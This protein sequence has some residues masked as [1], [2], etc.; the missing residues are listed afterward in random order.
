MLS[1]RVLSLFA[2][3][4]DRATGIIGTQRQLLTTLTGPDAATLARLR[5]ELMRVLMEFELFKLHDIFDPMIRHGDPQAAAHAW[6]M[7]GECTALGADVR[8]FVTRWSNG[9][10]EEQWEEFRCAKLALFDR[11]ERNFIDQRRA[12]TGM[13]TTPPRPAVNRPVATGGATQS[14]ATARDI[15]STCADRH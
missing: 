7:K 14:A 11:I 5:W 2:E 4:H 1:S 9:S 10:V 12:V 6:I 3:H 8:A 13:G 15:V